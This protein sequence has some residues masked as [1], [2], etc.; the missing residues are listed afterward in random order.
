MTEAQLRA[1][2]AVVEAG[3]FGEAARRLHLSQPGIS[4]AVGALE[5][6]LAGELFVRGRGAAVL[7][8]LG[9]RALARSRAMLREAD[10][11]RRERDELHANTSGHVRLGSMPS[12]SGTI[13]PGLL[14]RLERR[15]PA[16]SIAVLDGHDD[17][18]V[19]WVR[20]GTVDVAVVAGKPEGLELQPFV[21]DDLL[22]VV[23]T[24]HRLAT[25]AS[26]RAADL[27]DEPFILT[28]AGCERLVLATLASRG[29]TPSV[30]HEVTEASSIL[31]MV[32][33]GLGVSIMPSLAAPKPPATVALRPLAPRAQ[34][35]LALA[36]AP[37]RHGQ[38][39]PSAIR[40]FLDEAMRTPPSKARPR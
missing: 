4:R 9:E 37:R 10:A 26:V 22:A 15:H 6:E 24:G 28:R 1:F 23:P 13:L 5:A 2:V 19:T 3:G 38:Q 35:A 27:A 30:A 17:E 39:P 29:I 7:T 20:A 8:T 33:E 11:M 12:V 16:L 40:A 31:A 21:T 25:R 36:M 18:L 32:G 14:S 34:R